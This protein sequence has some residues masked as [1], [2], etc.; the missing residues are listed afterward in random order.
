MFGFSGPTL[1]NGALGNNC[2]RC[3]PA[4]IAAHL[5]G[6][7]LQLDVDGNGSVTPLT[8]GLL[9]LR[10]CSVSAGRRW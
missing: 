6:L 9:I 4:A 5:T 2:T 10:F 1:T 8:D 3:D 7:G